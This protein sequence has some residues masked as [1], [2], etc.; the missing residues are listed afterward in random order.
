MTIT[1]DDGPEATVAEAVTYRYVHPNGNSEPVKV[2][3]AARD[4][5]WCDHCEQ[6]IA[7]GELHAVAYRAFAWHF[8]LT[9]VER[10]EA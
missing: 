3:R 4:Y 7:R 5:P 1:T 2:R 10:V 9:C 8:C 6:P